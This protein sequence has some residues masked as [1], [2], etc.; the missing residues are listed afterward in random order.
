MVETRFFSRIAG[1]NE[2]QYRRSV[3]ENL[4]AQALRFRDVERFGESVTE[5][6]ISCE[7][8]ETAPGAFGHVFRE[9]VQV[10]RR[11]GEIDEAVRHRFPRPP[12]A[13]KCGRR[14]S[15]AAPSQ[16]FSSPSGRTGS[17]GSRPIRTTL[18]PIRGLRP[19]G[20]FE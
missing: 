20:R 2:D 9:L 5:F 11:P 19:G 1:Q 15:L 12:G 17:P 7:A 4:I 16:A 3:L 6:G 8:L 10:S 14:P 18:G 13:C